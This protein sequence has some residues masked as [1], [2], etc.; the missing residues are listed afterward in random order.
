MKVITIS[1]PE[2]VLESVERAAS[3]AGLNRSQ[4]FVESAERRLKVGDAREMQAMA[5]RLIDEVFARAIAVV[6]D[7]VANGLPP[8]PELSLLL[9]EP[10]CS[11]VAAA[12]GV[13]G[14]PEEMQACLNGEPFD[15]GNSSTVVRTCRVDVKRRRPFKR[16]KR[17]GS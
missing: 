5:H 13:Y 12:S 16:S 10:P 9:P 17:V 6:A 1:V 2:D 3:D 15:S 8:M 11:P 14:S 7:R 4:F